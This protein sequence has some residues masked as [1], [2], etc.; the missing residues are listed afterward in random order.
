MK[1][2]IALILIF[3]CVLGLAGCM[4]KEEKSLL[5]DGPWG[6]QAIWADNSR[7]TFLVCTK[8]PGETYA[9]VTAF[10]FTMAEWQAME[11]NLKKGTTAIYFNADGKTAMEAN[12]GMDGEKLIL[13]NF[14]IPNS[15]YSQ[16]EVRLILTKYDY[17]EMLAELPFEILNQLPK[18]TVI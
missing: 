18:E 16:M 13:S 12:A 2:L 3:A 1:K 17:N 14:Q 4:S 7:Q 9:T 8:K 10:L 15:N 6:S 5:T 11:V